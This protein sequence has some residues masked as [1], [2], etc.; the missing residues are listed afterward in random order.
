MAN[1]V[2]IKGFENKYAI[3]INGDVINI[4][5]KLLKKAFVNSWGYK[6]IC[7]YKDKKNYTFPVHRL[8]AES[9]LQNPEN[10]EQV[11]HID[12]NKLNNELSNLEWTTRSENL[13][14]AYKNNLSK[15]T[16]KNASESRKKIIINLYNGVFYN[17]LK[18]FAQ[19]NYLPKPYTIDNFKKIYKDK[20]AIV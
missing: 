8:V 20:F 18:E 3:N 17:G 9:F 4:H 13:I 15:V 5:T 10:K 11:N 16:T 7:L 2:P 12:G 19:S 14:H 6:N 1:F